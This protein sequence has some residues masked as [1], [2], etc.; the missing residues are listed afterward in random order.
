MILL[1]SNYFILSVPELF[2][3]IPLILKYSINVVKR[4]T[5]SDQLE[6]PSYVITGNMYILQPPVH[7]SPK[8]SIIRIFTDGVTLN[9]AVY[10]SAFILG[11]FQM[12]QASD[13]SRIQAVA[14]E[15][16]DM[17]LSCGYTKPA[18]FWDF[19]N[20]FCLQAML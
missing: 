11:L 15:A 8:L 3:I 12:Q 9:S 10:D 13:K 17:I 7:T 16:I 14:M 6:S 18:A 20:Y 4:W 1:R 19:N 2:F 5:L